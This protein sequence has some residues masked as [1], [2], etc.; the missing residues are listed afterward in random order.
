MT[1]AAVRTSVAAAA[2]VGSTRV[3][4]GVFV[5]NSP[6]AVSHHVTCRSLYRMSFPLAHV[7]VIKISRF[8]ILLMVSECSVHCAVF[9]NATYLKYN[10]QI[11]LE[12]GSVE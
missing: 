6:L 3:E 2:N 4:L 9:M 7:S 1:A 10:P 12:C 11:C 8:D 5:N